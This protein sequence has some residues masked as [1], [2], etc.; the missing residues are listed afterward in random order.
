MAFPQAMFPAGDI[1][2]AEWLLPLVI[3]GIAGA[4][5]AL[6]A[7]AYRH[8]VALDRPCPRDRRALGDQHRRRRALFTHFHRDGLIIA[9]VVSVVAGLGA[10]LWRLFAQLRPAARLEAASGGADGGGAA[11]HPARRRRRD[12]MGLAPARHR[13][14][15]PVRRALLCRPLLCRAA[16]RL[17]AAEAEDQLRSDPRAGHHPEAR[18]R[19]TRRR[20]RGRCARSA[21][22]SSPPRPRSRSRSAFPAR[23]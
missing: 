19:A 4:D 9:Y 15:R 8:D 6:A 2:G 20:W 16:G 14:P 17:D 13:H 10:A 3:F 23:R 21:S 18:R 11:Q 12:R 1:R 7:L 22:G 5:V